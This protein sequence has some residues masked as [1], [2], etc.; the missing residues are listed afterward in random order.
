MRRPY[1]AIVWW[2][3]RR[4]VFNLVVLVGGAFSFGIIEAIGVRLVDPGE[5]VVEPLAVIAGGAVFIIA[6]NICYTLGWI[7]ELMWSE[8]DTW[9]TEAIRQRVYRRGLLFSA[10]VAAAPGVLVP[11]MWFVFGFH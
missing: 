4:P 1:D 7:T 5:D 3:T 10:L 6:A 8:G 2:E 11:A 9:R